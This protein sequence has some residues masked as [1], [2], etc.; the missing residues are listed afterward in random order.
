M[1]VACYGQTT[2]KEIKIGT[3]LY[4]SLPGYMS[5]T[6]GLNDAAVFQY[7]ST[8]KDVYGFIIDDNK[9]ELK[10]AELNFTSI[11]EFYEAF[12]TGFL[13]GIEKKN[14]SN[15]LVQKKGN[16]NFLEADVTYFDKEAGIDIYYLVGIVETGSSFYKVLSW[17]DA[18]NKD[19][20]KADFQKILYSL[21]N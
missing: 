20:F 16:L 1:T 8:L 14:I 18:E 2:L 3:V 7:K 5:R 4:V 17:A 13:Q 11:N 10:L 19:K 6:I 9:E 15:P 12:I 21:K